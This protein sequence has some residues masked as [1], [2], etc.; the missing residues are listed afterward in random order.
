M[1]DASHLIG[2]IG[3][4]NARF[5]LADEAAGYRDEQILQCAEFESSITAIRHYLELIKAPAP[6]VICL[7][8]AGPVVD[9]R[10]SFTNNHWVLD[11]AELVG[12]FGIDEIV[13]INDFEAIAWSIPALPAEECLTIG[14]PAPR[15]LD[16]S[17]FTIAVAGPG[18]GLGAVGLKKLAGQLIAIPGEGSHSGFAPENQVQIEIL[19]AMRERYSRVSFERLVSGPGIEN[20]YWALCLVH[21][22]HRQQLGAAEVFA[23]AADG[24]DPRAAEAVQVFFEILGQFA[25]DLALTL[26]AHDGVFIAG[27][28]AKR[29]PELLENSRFRNGF[30]SKGRYRPQMERIPTQLVLHD[31]PGLLGASFCARQQLTG[32]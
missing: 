20:L 17:D 23:R 9:G 29:Y 5:A 26:N 6:D 8:A 25:G 27:G 14:L 10:V 18:T 4:T 2:D 1:P 13:L 30:E 21:G 16:R 31:H 24:S 22:E 15:S 32:S 19:K 7:A 12:E 28:I 3:G 11:V